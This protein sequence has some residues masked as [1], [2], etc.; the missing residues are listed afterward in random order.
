MSTID[1]LLRDPTAK[2]VRVMNYT[3]QDGTSVK[4]K[5][6]SE[7]VYVDVEPIVENEL[8]TQVNQ[9]LDS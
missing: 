1:R 6:E 8:W 9:I 3:T 4:L 5:P 7:W 2:G